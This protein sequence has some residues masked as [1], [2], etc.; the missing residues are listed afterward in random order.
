MKKLISYILTFL[1]VIVLIALVLIACIKEKVLN[2]D[3]ILQIFDNVNFYENT[4]K[5]LN[6]NFSNYIEQSGLDESVIKDIITVEDIKTEIRNCIESIYNNTKYTINKEDIEKR[7][8]E[9]INN[10]LEENHRKL[11]S[12]EEN[13]VSTFVSKISSVYASEVFPID[14]ISKININLKKISNIVDIA[15]ISLYVSVVVLLL[16]LIIINIKNIMK[17][18]NYIGVSL[19]SSGIVLYAPKIFIDYKLHINDINIYNRN[20][21]DIIIN[22]INDILNYFSKIPII[23]IVIAI[24]LLFVAN[25]LK[26][27]DNKKY[28]I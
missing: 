7:L 20:I 3:N 26:K 14:L 21:S 12:S 15:N 27:D 22:I 2:I 5:T 11:N 23:F 13:A 17:V 16:L 4:Y 28:N 6:E 24:V 9:N 18:L 25:L 1:L 8:N 19:L 10:Y